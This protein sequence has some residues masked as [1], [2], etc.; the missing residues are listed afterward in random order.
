[1]FYCCL[2]RCTSSISNER[3]WKLLL[4]A[5]FPTHQF[6]GVAFCKAIFRAS[7]QCCPFH[8]FVAAYLLEDLFTTPTAAC[9]SLC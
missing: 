7:S 1:L 6:A 8:D 2:L 3:N 9:S 4:G 5:A